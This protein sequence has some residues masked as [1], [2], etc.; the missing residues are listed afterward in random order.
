MENDIFLLAFWSKIVDAIH[1]NKFPNIPKPFQRT[2]TTNV[3]QKTKIKTKLYTSDPFE[4]E[5]PEGAW[6]RFRNTFGNSCLGRV[7]AGTRPRLNVLRCWFR[8]WGYEGDVGGVGEV[9]GVC[10]K[11]G[12]EVVTFRYEFEFFWYYE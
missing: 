3:K 1:I 8:R 6:L 12:R 2:T 5:S 11:R 7:R 9:R 10:V 4:S